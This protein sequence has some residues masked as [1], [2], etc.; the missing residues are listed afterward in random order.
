MYIK[1]LI[2]IICI[3]FTILLYVNSNAIECENNELLDYKI[4]RKEEQQIDKIDKLF[5][6][7]E[8]DEINDNIIIH[9]TFKKELIDSK[10]EKERSKNVYLD[11]KKKEKEILNKLFNDNLQKE[12]IENLQK[13]INNLK[14]EIITF[15]KLFRNDINNLL[16]DVKKNKLSIDEKKELLL[17]IKNEID[18][19]IDN[20]SNKYNNEIINLDNDVI[21]NLINI[22]KSLLEK[23]IKLLNK[24]Y[25]TY[26]KIIN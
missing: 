11:K 14:N 12:I 3:L 25:T 13:D 19:E 8:F 23:K 9:N 4:S 15:N 26:N 18:N 10:L 21:S 2:I 6:I 1:F 17:N 20:V 22:Y 16:N 24:K 7:K 5:N